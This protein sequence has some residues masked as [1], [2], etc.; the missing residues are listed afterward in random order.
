MSRLII[1][2]ALYF[3]IY[4]AAHLYLLIKWRRAFYLQ[5][6]EYFLLF[7]VLTFLLLA[8]INARILDNQG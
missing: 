4:G 7:V 1:F 3:S 8:P 5:G 6:M 2:L